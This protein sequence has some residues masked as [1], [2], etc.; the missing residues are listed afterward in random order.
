MNNYQENRD[1]LLPRRVRERCGRVACFLRS[2]KGHRYRC[3]LDV[4]RM[5]EEGS[6]EIV[7]NK[8][9]LIYD[10]NNG[11]VEHWN[12]ERL[13]NQ[14]DLIKGVQVVSIGRGQPVTAVC[15]L[16]NSQTNISHV[17]SELVAMCKKHMFPIPDRF[18]FV[19]DFPRIHTKI[20][21]YRIRE[22]LREG[23]ISVF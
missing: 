22:M 4:A 9:D 19:H 2:R 14:N 20:Q 15:V 6:I 16:R 1:S 7:A 18:A 11:L 17:R 3:P 21:K 12:I 5:D 13:L 23:R 8:E 10:N